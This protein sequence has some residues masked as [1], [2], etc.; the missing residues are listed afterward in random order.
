MKSSASKL[1]LVGYRALNLQSNGP[2]FKSQHQLH[3][4]HVG[5]F[6]WEPHVAVHARQGVHIHQPMAITSC[7]RTAMSHRQWQPWTAVS[8]L[9]GL[10]S[11]A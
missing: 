10:I 1:S 4:T 5:A 7:M 8:P 9:L 3:T 6:G 11:M 2:K